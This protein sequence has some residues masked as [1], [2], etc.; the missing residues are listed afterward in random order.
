MRAPLFILGMITATTLATGMIP[1]SVSTATAQANPFAPVITVNGLGITSFEIEQRATMISLLGASAD[2]R[3]QAEDDLINDRLQMSAAKR[4]GIVVSREAVKQGMEEFASRA[5]MSADQFLAAIASEGVEPQTFR[6]FVEAGIAWREVVKAKYA[7]KVNISD[8]DVAFVTAPEAERGKGTRLLMQEF[9]IPT[10][11]GREAE[12]AAIAKRV[13]EASSEASF[14]ALA[15]E[16]S[17]TSS[18]GAGGRLP[19]TDLA[20]VPPTL[21]PIMLGLE[22]GTNSAPIPIPNA[23]AVFRLRAIDEEGAKENGEQVLD[24]AEYLIPGLETEAGQSALAKV[25]ADAQTCND[26]YGFNKGQDPALLTR[27][28]RS[29][30]EIPSDVALQLAQMDANEISTAIRRGGNTV[31]LMLC[32]RTRPETDETP[33]TNQLRDRIANT[34]VGQFADGDLAELRA[35][36]VIQR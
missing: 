26:L 15:R 34:R 21:R 2:P 13:S 10:P 8:A 28:T 3:K 18:R 32:S 5:N 35:N 11:P 14:G 1:F 24:Y 29:L 17:A 19:W 7:G 9:I 30:P 25:Q 6:D 31:V 4:A 36:A 23:I 12:A 20:K 27:E 33:G 16:Y 22:P